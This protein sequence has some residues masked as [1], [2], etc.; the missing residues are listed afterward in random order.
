MADKEIP[1]NR[2]NTEGGSSP[3]GGPDRTEMFSLERN[4][5][6]DPQ[7]RQPVSKAHKNGDG[8]SEVA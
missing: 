6:H 2:W 3:L 8:Q 1:R 7:K 5:N 4:S